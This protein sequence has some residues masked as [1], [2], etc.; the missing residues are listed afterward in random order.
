MKYIF[1]GKQKIALCL[2]LNKNQK[3]TTDSILRPLRLLQVKSF[4]V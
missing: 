3:E 4:A 2:K 1:I